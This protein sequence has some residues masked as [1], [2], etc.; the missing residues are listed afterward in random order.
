MAE[1]GEAF[2]IRRPS[3]RGGMFILGAA[4]EF[5]FAPTLL[6]FIDF[7]RLNGWKRVINLGIHIN[8]AGGLITTCFSAQMLSNILPIVATTHLASC[9]GRGAFYGMRHHLQNG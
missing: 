6:Q 3:T 7:C 8:A 5:I 2:A 9:D 4:A 1:K